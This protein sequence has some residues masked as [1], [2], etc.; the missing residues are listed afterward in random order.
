[1]D[2]GRSAADSCLG[3]SSDTAVG[4]LGSEGNGARKADNPAEAGA[5]SESLT[6]D[7][8]DYALS[9]AARGSVTVAAWTLISR[10]TGLLR[11]VVIGAV[12]GP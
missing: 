11:V 6:D 9:G 5:V 4:R 10:I 8:A 3:P 12:L 7:S 2:E 1:M